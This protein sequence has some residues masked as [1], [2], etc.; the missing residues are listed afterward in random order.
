MLSTHVYHSP[1]HTH[2]TYAYTHVYIGSRKKGS[3]HM[4]SGEWWNRPENSKNSFTTRP[5]VKLPCKFYLNGFCKHVS[6]WE[7]VNIPIMC[8]R[9]QPTSCVC[10]CVCVCREM[11]VSLATMDRGPRRRACV[12]STFK[13]PAQK[14]IIVSFIMVCVT[15]IV[16]YL[17]QGFNP[18]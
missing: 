2:I 3:H 1:K 14:E 11:S 17:L 16:L 15:A 13:I 10:V 6:E 4:Q 7:C 12:N 18:I 9:G 5:S 8:W